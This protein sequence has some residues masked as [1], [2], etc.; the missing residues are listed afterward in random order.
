V[1]TGPSSKDTR[2]DT[3]PA[4]S[5][6]LRG[7]LLRE[8]FEDRLMDLDTGKLSPDEAWAAAVNEARMVAS[9]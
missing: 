1:A 8:P 2:H 3:N 6:G 4:P 5:R 9:G 7:G